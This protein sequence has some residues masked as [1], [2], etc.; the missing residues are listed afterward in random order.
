MSHFETFGNAIFEII[1]TSL[2]SD[3]IFET[4]SHFNTYSLNSSHFK[5]SR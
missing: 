3:M 4:E 1:E 2:I 5:V